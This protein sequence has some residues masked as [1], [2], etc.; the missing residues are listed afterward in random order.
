[1]VIWYGLVMFALQYAFLFIG[2]YAGVSPGVAAILLQLQV[3][4]TILLGVMCFKEKIHLWQILGALVSC[5]GIAFILLN[6]GGNITLLGCLLVIGS[7]LSWGAGNAISKQIGKVDVISLVIW[8]S[9]VA[10]PLFL[11]LNL[12]LEGPD[13][14]LFVARHLSWLSGGAILYITF[15]STLV[16]FGIWSWL[17]HHHPTGTVAPFT[18]LIPIF[19]ILSSVLALG[20][21]LQSWKIIAALLV[22]GG[23][24]VNLLGP[25]LIPKRK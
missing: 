15:V 13:K 11:I 17:I 24:G 21:P 1:M 2:M 4:F 6:L 18:L 19:G 20:E 23:L 9:L 10:W 22:I 8:G 16:A 3:F 14:I 12:F 5:S 7:A 25:R